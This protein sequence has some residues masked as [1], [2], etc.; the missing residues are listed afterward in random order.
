VR[1]EL[2]TSG[3]LCPLPLL[4]AK[5]DMRKL[6]SGDELVV[7]ATDPEAAVDFGAWVAVEGHTL[8]ERRHDDR[9]VFTI[10]KA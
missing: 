9:L 7:T 4:L 1:R 5:R 10:V 3:S 6:D 2:D 8:T